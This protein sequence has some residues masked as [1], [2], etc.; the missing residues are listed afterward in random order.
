[1]GAGPLAA[2]PGGGGQLGHPLLV[3]LLAG[4]GLGFQL[5]FGVLQPGQPLGPAGQR[6]RQL[7]A[8]GRAVLA[9]L[10]LICLGGLGEQ[11]G[12]LGLERGVGAVRRGSGVGLDLGAIQGDQTAHPTTMA[13][14][15]S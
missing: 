1:V 4:G 7:V 9:V 11:L 8:A 12:D 13:G 2:G 5:G 10:G 3:A 6:L 15:W 14:G